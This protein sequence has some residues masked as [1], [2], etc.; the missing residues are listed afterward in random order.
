MQGLIHLY[1]GDGKGKTTAAMGLVVRALGR[2]LRAGIV[3][4]LKNTPTGEILF[5]EKVPNVSILRG[6]DGKNFSFSMTLEQKTNTRHIHNAH[7]EQARQWMLSGQYDLILLDEICAAYALDLID[8]EAVASFLQQK[9]PSMELILTGRDPA[10]LLVD[11]AD[12]ITEMTLRRHPFEKGIPARR[13]IE[14]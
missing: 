13:G 3:Q 1:C 9:P 8:R 12:Y 6:Q 7:L 11:A 2:G 4:F 14:F 10:P 5:L